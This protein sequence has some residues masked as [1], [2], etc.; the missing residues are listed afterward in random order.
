MPFAA[1]T[2][3]SC[4][5]PRGLR[6][7]F[8][9]IEL[10]VVIAIIA[11]LIALLLPAV[12][13]AR[14]A[15]RRSQCKNNLKQLGLALHNYHDVYNSFP[16]GS[17]AGHP[18]P[19][20]AGCNWRVSILPY[21]EQAAAFNKLNFSGG[22][23]ASGTFDTFSV[24]FQGNE[25][26][27]G[28]LVSAYKCP[29]SPIHAFEDEPNAG[30]EARLS[31]MPDY[32][33]ISGAAPDPA[34]RTNVVR[35]TMR[36]IISSSGLLIPTEAKGVRDAVDGLSNTIVVAEQS[37]YVG[38]DV[39]RSNYMGAWAGAAWLHTVSA[40]PE[41]D[42]FYHAGLTTVY[43]PINSKTPIAATVGGPGSSAPYETNTIVNSM[44]TGG[45]HALLGDGAVRFISENVNMDTLRALSAANDGQVVGEW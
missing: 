21:L 36:G 43:S 42:N 45:V 22:S 30:N 15:A 11:V 35:N 7:G 34:G 12:Q 25:V 16:I 4:R 40:V 31:M 37:G 10:L 29:S 33:G 20:M 3:S 24:P 28:L 26:L 2:A 1:S 18:I 17:R 32:V 13:Q 8:T 39:I 6:R 5:Q 44:H 19:N 41:G 38:R 14:E 23:F 9:L 27:S